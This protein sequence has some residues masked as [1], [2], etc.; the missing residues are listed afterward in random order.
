MIEPRIS[1]RPPLPA[2]S[3]PPR[4]EREVMGDISARDEGVG[5]ER[6]RFRLWAVNL[7]TPLSPLTP[8]PPRGERGVMEERGEMGERGERGE[9]GEI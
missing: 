4:V 2:H 9:R 8:L 7:I 6:F 1:H 3:P 5:G